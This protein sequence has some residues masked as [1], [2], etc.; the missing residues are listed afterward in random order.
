MRALFLLNISLTM[1]WYKRFV[2]PLA[3]NTIKPKENG[4]MILSK[5][6]VYR[7]VAVALFFSAFYLNFNIKTNQIAFVTN[8][9]HWFTWHP[10]MTGE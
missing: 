1:S 3:T 8:E 2:L 7:A 5:L 4:I 6:L 9:Y 10:V